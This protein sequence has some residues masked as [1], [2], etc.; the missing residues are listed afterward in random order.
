[1][2]GND[3]LRCCRAEMMHG[4]VVLRGEMCAVGRVE[5]LCVQC[6]AGRVGL[7]QHEMMRLR[8]W[9][10]E[11]MDGCVGRVQRD[12]AR[13]G[14]VDMSCCSDDVLVRCSGRCVRCCAGWHGCA[15]RCV[16]ALRCVLDG[17]VDVVSGW[18]DEACG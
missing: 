8:C 11:L 2:C 18:V 5:E 1:M 10:A 3:A 16:D 13:S 14:W 9:R 17:C 4:C 6:R 12:A 15:V 7:M